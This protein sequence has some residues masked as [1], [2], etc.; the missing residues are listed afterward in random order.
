MRLPEPDRLRKRCLIHRYDLGAEPRGATGG[1]GGQS[2]SA[3][4]RKRRYN[5]L[6]MSITACG[7]STIASCVAWSST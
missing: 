6:M 4:R 3:S 5:L 2:G 1:P 7:W